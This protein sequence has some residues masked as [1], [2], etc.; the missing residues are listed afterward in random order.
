MNLLY[1]IVKL[2][3]YLGVIILLSKY[4]LVITLRNLAENL[5]LK[6]K[7]VG[8]VAGYATSMPEL[9]TISISSFSGLIGAS[10]YNVL[11]SNIINLIQYAFSVFINK[12]QKLLNNKAIQVSCILV[13]FTIVIPFFMIILKIEMNLLIVPF[14]FFMYFLFRYISQKVHEKYLSNEDKKIE[15]EILE[16][17]RKHRGNKKELFKNI[18]YLIL[19]GILLFF[20]GDMLGDTLENLCNIFGISQLLIGIALGFA[21]SMPELITFIESQK[22]YKSRD[23]RI[24]GMVEASNNLLASNILNLFIIQSIG[25]IIYCFIF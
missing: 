2:T 24:L 5:N 15:E 12:N 11:S 9:L 7:T 17:D 20:I 18:M 19:T 8:E 25:I 14:F 10:I 16:N 23:N 4:I 21:T 22:H 6:P 1:E 13:V 3:V